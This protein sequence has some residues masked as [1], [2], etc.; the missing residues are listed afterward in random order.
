MLK[1]SLS[2]KQLKFIGLALLLFAQAYY[3]Y[4]WGADN[5]AGKCDAAKI[6]AAKQDLQVERK[7]ADVQNKPVTDD[8]MLERLRRAQ[9]GQL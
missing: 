3:F 9:F 1:P 8:A 4:S 2:L 5:E 6:N 7:Q